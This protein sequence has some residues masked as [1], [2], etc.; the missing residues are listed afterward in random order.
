TADLLADSDFSGWDEGI[1]ASGSGLSV[2]RSTFEQNGIGMNLGVDPNG[3]NYMLQRSSFNNL[4][5]TANNTAIIANDIA[6]CYFS[7]ISIQGS[8][9]APSGQSQAGLLVNF[10][11][12]STFSG[13]Q[14]GGGYSNAAAI[15]AGGCSSVYYACN[16][17]N[18]IP[19][20]RVWNVATGLPGVSFSNT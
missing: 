6:N 10:S 5:L 20:G 4:A 8:T 11:Q 14:I 13:V 3:N 9:Y 16:A 7:A 17:S 19:T 2:I 18:S 12:G 1:R 15:V